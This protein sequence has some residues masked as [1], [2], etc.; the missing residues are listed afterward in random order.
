MK[1]VERRRLERSYFAAAGLERINLNL[2]IIFRLDDS[3][4]PLKELCLVM[5]E[6]A[7]T[8]DALSHLN[9][10]ETEIVTYIERQ[11]LKTLEGVVRHLLLC[12][13]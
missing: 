10:I 13:L 4:A 2:R 1:K 3:C 9:D 12:T 7:F 5:Q 6:D 11:F 8:L